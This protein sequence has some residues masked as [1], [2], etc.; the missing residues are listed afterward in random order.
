[1]LG[2]FLEDVLE[3]S[4]VVVSTTYTMFLLGL[5]TLVFSS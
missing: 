4:L 2:M 5:Q 1:M 3:L